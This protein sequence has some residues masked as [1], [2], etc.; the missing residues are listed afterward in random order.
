[1]SIEKRND[2]YTVRWRDTAGKQRSKQVVLWRDAVALDGDLKRRKAMG[3]LITHERG[4]MRVEDFWL[5]WLERYGRTYLTPRTLE[6]YTQ[7]WAK[8]VGPRL[9]Y[10]ELRNVTPEDVADLTSKLVRKLAPSSVHKVL[11]VVQGVFQRAV[12]WQYIATNP[13]SR[14][15]KPLLVT[16]E[17][18]ALSWDQMTALTLELPNLRDRTIVTVLAGSGLRPGELRALRWADVSDTGITVSRAVSGSVVG[19][20]KTNQ[21]RTVVLRPEVGGSLVEWS[22]SLGLGKIPSVGRQRTIFRS[23]DDDIWSDQGWRSWQRGVFAPAASRAGFPGLVPYDLRHTFASTLIAE[24]RDIYW[25][26]RQLGH[27]PTMT[28]NTYGHLFEAT[29]Q[30]AADAADHHDARDQG[31]IRGHA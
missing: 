14:A 25:I 4:H 31:Q 11:A 29:Y 28:L 27:S 24:G 2:G 30:G 16:R 20:T 19:P 7:L 10:A 12:E 9:G 8:H 26:A 22:F 5:L 15:R 21:R 13:A 17:G 23:R 18:V 1:M 6:N 3:D